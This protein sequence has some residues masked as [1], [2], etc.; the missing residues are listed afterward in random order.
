M[1]FGHAAT[2]ADVFGLPDA[3]AAHPRK[4][5]DYAPESENGPSGGDCLAAQSAFGECLA[6]LGKAWLP[7]GRVAR[8]A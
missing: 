6:V 2:L 7:P 4:Q 1:K 8:K 5:A 3:Q